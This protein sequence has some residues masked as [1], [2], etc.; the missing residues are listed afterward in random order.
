MFPGWG[1]GALLSLLLLLGGCGSGGRGAPWNILLITID[2]LR[3]DRLGCYGGTASITPNIDRLA[4][5]GTLFAESY[6]AMPITLPSH[7]SILTGLYPRNHRVL[8]HAYTLTSEFTTL[9]EI[10]KANG[11]HTAAFVSS[12][13][14]DNKYGLGQGFDLY[15]KRYDY[16][17]EQVNRIRRESGFDI[18]T[19]AVET[20]AKM[21]AEEPYFTWIHWFHPHKPY[22][23]PPPYK[24]RYDIRADTALE[25]SVETF[26]KAWKR[27][28]ELTD[29]E[30]E[31]MR[32]LY[33]G[34]VA[35]NDRQVGLT[36]RKLRRLGLLERTIIILTADHGEMLY[37]K[38]RYFG[39]DIMLYDP[40]IRVPLIM[41][42]PGL[43][44]EGKIALETVRSVDLLPTIIELA[45]LDRGDDILDGRSVAS[46]FDGGTIEDLPVFAE[47][48]GPKPDWKSPPRHAVRFENWKL[49]RT[50]GVE[51]M[52]LYDLNE[53]PLEKVNLA[54]VATDRRDDLAD[55]LDRL[56]SGEIDV[57]IPVLTE[58]ER[59]RLE[60]LGYLD[61]K[62]GSKR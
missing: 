39:H 37:E 13:V 28:I 47:M 10:A 8:S 27:E 5:E 50:D 11:Y 21:R 2:T 38:D 48:F 55:R 14:V 29:R 25:A 53:D 33:A 52:E 41:V 23:P 20:W 22:E 30:L 56:M 40:S 61:R 17:P 24:A 19:E 36:L 9:A 58:E 6:C 18:L 4:A 60:A 42:A 34:E 44:P 46:L 15:W 59:I 45:G 51:E 35:Y 57:E 7:T 54:D 16:G 43:I 49:I 31:E 62:K 26:R 3:A 1:T 32:S 12:H